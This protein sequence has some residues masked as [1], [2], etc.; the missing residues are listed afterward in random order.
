ME[1]DPSRNNSPVVIQL[2]RSV[3]FAQFLENAASALDDIFKNG[4]A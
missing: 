1:L 3:P 2:A 4:F